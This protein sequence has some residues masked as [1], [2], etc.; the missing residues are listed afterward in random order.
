MGWVEDTTGIDLSPGSI[1]KT[2]VDATVGIVSGKYLAKG[3]GIVVSVVGN[4][5][6]DDIL[7][8]DKVGKEV[9]R[10]GNQI[11]QVGKA[12]GG[13]YHD[14]L[15]KIQVMESNIQTEVNVYNNNVDVLVD[16]MESLIAFHEIFKMAASNRLDEYV[17]KYGAQLDEL[18]AQYQAA[19]QQLR[20]EYDFI[21]GLTEGSFL[22]KIVVSLIMII[23]GIMSDM[24]DIMSGKADGD[25]WKRLVTTIVLVIAVV[26]MCFFPP[27]WGSVAL[28]VGQTLAILGALITLDGM[29]ANGAAT[30]AIMGMLDTIFNDVLKLDE[31]IGRDFD[32]FDKDNADYQEM[33]MYVQLAIAL[34]SV[35]N[36]WQAGVAAESAKVVTMETASTT[37][38]Q[39]MGIAGS[40]VSMSAPSSIGE[41]IARAS[42]ASTTQ[43]YMGGLVEINNANMANSTMA[44]VKFGTYS[45]IYKAY[46]TAQSINDVVN[47][48]EQY[49]ELKNKLKEDQLKVEEAITSKITKGFVKSYKDTAYFL[50]DQQEQL[51]RYL[52]SMTAQ[53][54][55]VDPYGT[56][57]VANSRFTPDKDTRMMSFGYEDIF[58]E[59]KM[60][61]S[62]S[63]FSNIIYG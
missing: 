38:E 17:G 12:L 22:E 13:D 25:T 63:Y 60:A 62:K 27:A 9:A 18:I 48:N 52:W 56:T 10:V 32:K 51:N 11:T 54:M 28:V 1:I 36:A 53:N 24:G 61:G 34:A 49:N 31:V 14:E 57:P 20:D 55:Y 7:G 2:A 5:V 30:G 58:D 50:Q 44:G 40:E 19:V 45:Q 59:S 46:S 35:A 37:F 47:M 23:G 43:S 21:V 15:K 39:T 33:V 3:A 29:Y 42:S 6:L 8:L 4:D 16:K 41:S 26:I